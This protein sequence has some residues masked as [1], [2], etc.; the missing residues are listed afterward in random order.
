VVIAEPVGVLREIERFLPI[1]AG[2]HLRRAEAGEE[3]DAELHSY[4]RFVQSWTILGSRETAVKVNAA[5]AAC[6]RAAAR[7][8]VRPCSAR[9][10]PRRRGGGPRAPAPRR[11]ANLP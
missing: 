1:A 7:C 3:V 6:R 5:P 11:S 9:A 4:P 8:G 10:N 2:R